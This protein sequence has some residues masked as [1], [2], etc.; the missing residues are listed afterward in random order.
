MDKATTILPKG[1]SEFPE[2]LDFERLRA[3][4]L[5]HIADLSGRIWTDHNVHDPGIT[6]LEALCYALTDL[7]Y[8]TNLPDTDLFARDPLT[9]AK[10]I[11]DDNFATAADIL[12]SNPLTL[13]DYRKLLIDIDGVRNAWIEPI[14]TIP[15]KE[16]ELWTA[17]TKVYVHCDTQK[18]NYI[19][20]KIPLSI[21]GVY[22]VLLELEPNL[23]ATAQANE[24]HFTP[25]VTANVLAEV[26]KR[27]QA[28]RNLCEDFLSISVLRDEKISL[29]AS[30]EI[31]SDA[32]PDDVALRMFERLQEFLSPT[33][34][35]YTLSEML[36]K[37][38]TVDEIFEGRP[39]LLDSRSHGFIDTDELDKIQRRDKLYASDII[40]VLLD[41]EGVEAVINLRLFSAEIDDVQGKQW[42]MSL[43][44]GFRPILDAAKTLGSITFIKRDVPYLAN[45]TRVLPAFEKRLLNRFKSLSLGEN[46]LNLPI[47][48]GEYRSDLGEYYSIQHD[49]PNVYGIGQ[50]NLPSQSSDPT[51]RA[52]ALQ[53][54]GYLLFY[55]HLF[56]NYLA[57][58]ANN[59]ALF[60]PRLFNEKI[61]TIAAKQ[62]AER[63]SEPWFGLPAES[64]SAAASVGN[65]AKTMSDGTQVVP[66][67]E[68]L[69]SFFQKNTEGAGNGFSEGETVAVATQKF[70]TPQER[71]R[72]M[73]QVVD[74]FD[75]DNIEIQY[76]KDLKT[77]LYTFKIIS[78]MGRQVFM[79]SVKTFKTKDDAVTAADKIRFIATLPES[80]ER[81]DSESKQ[82]YYG[83][84]L[85][86]HTPQYDT[87]LQQIIENETAFFNRKNRFFDHLLARFSEDFTDYTLLMFAMN[88]GGRK[89]PESIEL[90][91]R[92]AADKS[93][94]LE[95]Y[96]DI[97]HNRSK[98]FNYKETANLLSSTNISG[99]ENRVS[100][101]I[102]IVPQPTKM[103][104][105]FDIEQRDLQYYF[106][107]KDPSSTVILHSHHDC[108]TRNDAEIALNQVFESG[109]YIENFEPTF[110]LVES[111][112]GF[113]LLDKEGGCPLAVSPNTFG[114]AALR[115]TKM[116]YTHGVL[117]G[118]GFMT[119]FQTNTEGVHFQLN[120]AAQKPLFRSVKAMTDE[121][122]AF[123]TYLIFAQN[124]R[125]FE[126]WKDIDEPQ[127]RGF[128]FAVV[129]KKAED[130]V[131]DM[132]ALHPVFYDS[133]DKRKSA[134]KTAFAFI[135][136]KKQHWQTQ[137]R[138][139]RFQWQLVD[140]QRCI[141]LQSI[142]FFKN[143]PHTA[144]ALKQSLRG[145]RMLDNFELIDDLP[146]KKCSFYLLW[147]ATGEDDGVPSETM[148]RVGQPQHSFNS[149]FERDEA[150]AHIRHLA[151]HYA[152]KW[153]DLGSLV[154]DTD[155]EQFLDDFKLWANINASQGKV[156]LW[157]EPS[158]YS[159]NWL[160]KKNE[161]GLVSDD[162]FPSERVAKG[163]VFELENKKTT[164]GEVWTIKDV[165]ANKNNYHGFTENGGCSF[166]FRLETAKIKAENPNYYL[167]AAKRDAAIEQF[168]TEAQA[169]TW[170]SI[171]EKKVASWRFEWLAETPDE[172]LKWI[173]RGYHN[174]LTQAEAQGDAPICKGILRSI[175]IK[176][177]KD[178]NDI[179]LNDSHIERV[180]N[181]A[182]FQFFIKNDELERL[183]E[184][185]E[186]ATS[187]ERDAALI[188]LINEA[189]QTPNKEAIE[190]TKI[191]ECADAGGQ[192]RTLDPRIW[193]VSDEADRLAKLSQ[194]FENKEV[195]HTHFMTLLGNYTCEPPHYAQVWRDLENVFSD[196]NNNY[197]FLLRDRR[198][199]Y[200]QSAMP[201]GSADEARAA[202]DEN[203]LSI[204][205]LAKD[206]Q[207][208]KVR[209]RTDKNGLKFFAIELTDEK[210]KTVAEAYQK[211]T[212]T[213]GVSSIM[214]RLKEH[215]LS[216]PIFME[217]GGKGFG[218]H[219]YDSN[220]QRI[221]WES[222][223][224]YTQMKEA[225]AAFKRFLDLLKNRN[226]YRLTTE[227][228]GKWRIELVETLLLDAELFATKYRQTDSESVA[229]DFSWRRV[230]VFL[231]V[232]AKAGDG[233]FAPTVDYM[234]CCG[235]GFQVV[236]DGYRLARH[237]QSFHS[238]AER[239]AARD[240]LW[241]W[242]R[243]RREQ[244]TFNTEGGDESGKLLKII[245]LRQSKNSFKVI[246]KNC[247][248]TYE[249]KDE[250][251]VVQ[252]ETIQQTRYIIELR[253][254]KDS[255]KVIYQYE[256]VYPDEESANDA[257]TERVAQSLEAANA[258]VI[259]ENM[260][261]LKQL[262]GLFVLAVSR[263]DGSVI[264]VYEELSV[265]ETDMK[266]VIQKIYQEANDSPIV[267][268]I[269]GGF[270]FELRRNKGTV[271]RTV[272][273]FVNE[274]CRPI[275]IDL[276][277][278]E[279][280]WESIPVYKTV[281]AAQKAYAL[282]CLALLDNK[283]NYARLDT[284]AD[285]SPTLVLV[286]PDYVVAN[287]P[288]SYTT[289][290]E[291]QKAWD[292][293]RQHIH[294]EGMHL[295]EH[296]LLRPRMVDDALL[297]IEP[298][299]LDCTSYDVD[300]KSLFD[301]YIMGADPYSFWT[302][303]VLPHWS[304]RFRDID[305]R[306]FFENTLRRE[307]PAHV[308]V[309]VF[310]VNPQQMQ[311]FE[312][313]FRCWLDV[314][315]DTERADYST[316]KSCF[317]QA[318]NSLV[319]VF[320]AAVLH[321]CAEGSED[322]IVVLDKTTLF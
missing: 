180:D 164:D 202:F 277:V 158:R 207:N 123:E 286:N 59:R 85:V 187:T 117:A 149:V 121:T 161:L 81:N 144:R 225:E 200:W 151:K 90:S 9:R 285:G 92:F 2:Y 269:E 36:D 139:T 281:E 137:Q 107:I 39:M 10:A 72:A 101:L 196:V 263:A 74:S 210:D 87:Y 82:H 306:S 317:V 125:I 302:T 75:M 130:E 298:D 300:N 181:D 301:D 219:I 251:D 16:N 134:K 1:I 195:A 79:K 114:T 275:E 231:D 244:K 235:Y 287:H 64:F 143:S 321:D 190:S 55:D 166:F 310:W 23:L 267:E 21:R 262:N 290:A 305:F 270:G 54:K 24:C 184:S 198:Y 176:K 197:F 223:L 109:K 173:L 20:N 148:I 136:N 93:R 102:G 66:Q 120:D 246:S 4:G 19:P 40:R 63:V 70:G 128:G 45:A 222:S 249:F 297:P 258:A 165:A 49:F 217:K 104:N 185:P 311:L 168:A 140:S 239:E 171:L 316:V 254:D 38:K 243:V 14:E 27:L 105:Y 273:G 41:T 242:W 226:H 205:E 288:R 96:A 65:L 204:I 13:L 145:A 126:H 282:Q 124:V 98:G 234:N 238:V 276:P 46:A 118:D 150:I 31:K 228:V 172:R 73:L 12:G 47:P 192:T 51:R 315:N 259:L 309:R 280:V 160:D 322:E 194:S 257:V 278:F 206:L 312:K 314:I 76:E 95:N 266:L 170:V 113:R 211:P 268:H 100:K 53:L 272:R 271:K 175:I 292:N 60:S 193:R 32:R 220:N 237:P 17:E 295:V 167:D 294:T 18:L 265:N 122:K 289:R 274:D 84:N 25:D 308:A 169:D 208:Y 152:K 153:D 116:A 215:A 80:Y 35:F 162:L 138:A 279:V 157:K 99:L 291:R 155:E 112:Y 174:R 299:S 183:A 213:E 178:G 34:R 284:A 129:H 22:K 62:A 293:V 318:M 261:V 135:K 8:R 11:P 115:D 110:C 199:I 132:L 89:Q 127:G 83:F 191:C 119:G 179:T 86:Y 177:D 133:I 224:L 6:I 233:A 68:Q 88:K 313:R 77:A 186:F 320:P 159:L 227:C 247:N 252:K 232:L 69:L 255:S 42:E 52:Q 7:G 319:S 26:E 303:V 256:D 111:V 203:F 44:N 189:K 188:K 147:K 216:F 304:E 218:F 48:A 91:R 212:T 201:Y 56:A 236:A 240:A 154:D 307:A 106:T 30:I 131:A 71:D 283:N 260:L 50:D 28:H 108:F 142:H 37:G 43:K 253:D 33:I 58:L 209:Q 296:L 146:H 264:T 5:Q 3:E 61:G 15:E 241:H 94:F 103:L 141:V 97:S 29:C 221:E 230:G 163:A 182:V 78:T 245:V 67:F 248:F 214:A 156:Q 250:N 229:L 57:Q